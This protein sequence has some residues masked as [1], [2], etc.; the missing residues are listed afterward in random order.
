MTRS[1]WRKSALICAYLDRVD[2]RPELNSPANKSE[3]EGH[4]LDALAGSLLDGL[5]V[6]GR[7]I[8]RPENERSPG[9]IRHETAR[10]YRMINLWEKEIDPS[11]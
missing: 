8:L 4:R 7:E 5:S 2:G 9:V 11:P 10:A 1:A 6:W 3:W